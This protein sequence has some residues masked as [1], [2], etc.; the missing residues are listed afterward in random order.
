[1]NIQIISRVFENGFDITTPTETLSAKRSFEET[2]IS[3]SSGTHIARVGKESFFSSAYNIIISGGG[4]YQFKR[5]KCYK[6]SKP[7]WE[8]KGEGRSFHL[9]KRGW[10]RFEIADECQKIAEFRRAWFDSDYEISVVNEAEL[11]LIICL[12][13]ALSESEY[14]SSAAPA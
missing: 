13:L 2:N 8:C 12:V 7:T 3:N 14:R 6:M 5:D 10:R 1:M 9:Y 4:F 11:K